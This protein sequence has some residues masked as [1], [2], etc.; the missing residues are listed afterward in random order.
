MMIKL[1]RYKQLLINRRDVTVTSGGTTHTQ[2]RLY[3][4]K[5]WA[6]LVSVKSQNIFNFHLCITKYSNY[7][8]DF[9]WS[10]H[11][12]GRLRIN[13]EPKGKAIT[14][15]FFNTKCASGIVFFSYFFEI[16]HC[17]PNKELND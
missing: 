14:A 3:Y 8:E 12:Q 15:A 17:R 6:L 13:S 9:C 10:V 16:S 4:F 1:N 5:L 7:R 2:P 11:S